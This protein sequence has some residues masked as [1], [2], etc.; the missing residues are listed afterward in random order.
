MKNKTKNRPE[1][2]N[3]P[4]H[5]GQKCLRGVPINEYG[6]LKKK[7]TLNLTP[8]A[9]ALLDALSKEQQISKSEVIERILRQGK[10]EYEPDIGGVATGYV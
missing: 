7:I 9:I 1:R 2:V 5:K 10:R 6:E 8:S 4:S 3:K